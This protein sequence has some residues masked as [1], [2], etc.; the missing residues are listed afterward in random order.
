MYSMFFKQLL[1]DAKLDD[2]LDLLGRTD[3][4]NY[5]KSNGKANLAAYFLKGL[6]KRKCLINIVLSFI[7]Y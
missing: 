2:I 1:V 4:G 6:I 7:D 5:K 3:W